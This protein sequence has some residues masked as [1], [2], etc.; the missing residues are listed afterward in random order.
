[1]LTNDGRVAARQDSFLS[2][3]PA[4]LISP[5]RRPPQASRSCFDLSINW[6][7]PS[8]G[9]NP[10]SG[11]GGLQGKA[12]AWRIPLPGSPPRPRAARTAA[13]RALGHLALATMAIS[14]ADFALRQVAA[15]HGPRADGVSAHIPY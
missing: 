14:R 9:Q 6:R 2:P 13:L 1:M 12:L 7:N 5:T 15:A 4:S 11:R 8:G 10:S 3:G